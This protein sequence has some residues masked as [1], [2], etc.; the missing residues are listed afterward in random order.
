[1]VCGF[2]ALWL[3]LEGRIGVYEWDLHTGEDDDLSLL[4]V[5]VCLRYSHFYRDFRKICYI[6]IVI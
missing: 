6:E 3:A 2:R 5:V 4:V 1:M